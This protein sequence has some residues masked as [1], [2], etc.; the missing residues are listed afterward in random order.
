M[1]EHAVRVLLVD[2]DPDDALLI[3]DVFEDMEN[4]V[5]DVAV[6]NHSD[7]ALARLS[8]ETFD[9]VLCDYRMGSVT[10]LDFIR[11]ARADGITIPILLLTGVG[12]S[13][14]DHRAADAGASDFLAKDE[15]TPNVL[16]RSIRYAIAASERQRLLHAVLDGAGT[17]VLLVRARSEVMLNNARAAHLATLAHGDLEGAA[18]LTAL[19]GDVLGTSEPE[20]TISDRVLERTVSRF[21]DDHDLIVLYD[22]TDR[23]RV[24]EERERAQRVLAHAARH[25]AL[26]GLGNRTGFSERLDDELTAALAR[27]GRFALMSFD[28]DRF[29]E[30]NDVHG[31]AA[32]DELLRAVAQ[33]LQGAVEDEVYL[34]RLGGD[35]FVALVPFGEAFLEDGPGQAIALGRRMHEELS[36]P[37]VLDERNLQVQ[38]SIGITIY[39]DHGRDARTLLANADLAMYRAK[40]LV[41]QAVCIFDSEMDEAVRADRALAT[42]MR[43]CLDSDQ[44]TTYVQPQSCLQTGELT[45]FE[46]LA[47][48]QRPDG[49]FVPPDRFIAVAERSGLILPLGEMLINKGM[50]AA[51]RWTSRS[52][53]ALNVSAVQ[54][55]HG[56]I[57]ALLRDGMVRYG[58]SPAQLE[59]E[60]T[61]TAL[62]DHS[63]RAIQALRQIRG[64]G[65]SI[66][67][68]DFGTGYSSLAM[69][70]SF[71][72]DKIKIDRS[73]VTELDRFGNAAIVRSVAQLGENLNATVLVEGVEDAGQA[74]QLRRL[75]CRQMQGYLLSKPFPAQ[76]VDAW[77]EKHRRSL[78]A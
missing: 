15:L 73:F 12:T 65:I 64:M 66:A 55:N 78:A 20:L 44:F 14:L 50:E 22:I 39:P 74:A 11:A 30:I 40:G 42:E 52:R 71:P 27:S 62:L 28:L 3:C 69:L 5:H 35:E 60:I 58:L 56:D 1:G 43:D 10:G 76:E 7:R 18:A 49:T 25:D 47:R 21:D 38:A 8:E 72:F 46:A 19:A 34:A 53:I 41:G 51:S 23:A 4:G 29:K 67:L 59:V 24:L 9:V 26:T 37:C 57:V 54:L 2:D 36:R 13:E 33:R 45:G 70:Q 48:W 68:D 6:E 77:V 32:G 16:D 63:A 31:H 17:A 75:G 61:E